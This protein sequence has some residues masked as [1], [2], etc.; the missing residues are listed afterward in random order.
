MEHVGQATPKFEQLS[1]KYFRVNMFY[2]DWINGN[3]LMQDKVREWYA[4]M[5]ITPPKFL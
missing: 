1:E 3:S 4:E 5:N 2:Y